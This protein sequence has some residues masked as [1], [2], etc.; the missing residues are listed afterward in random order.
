VAPP[1]GRVL[2]RS[3]GLQPGE[4]GAERSRLAVGGDELDPRCSPALVEDLAGVAPAYVAT[5]GFDPLRD[6]GEEYA[7][8]LRGDGVGVALRRH[9]DLIHGFVNTV[10]VGH[11]GKDALLEAAGALRV[12]VARATR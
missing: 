3:D 9:S 1:L 6:E 12:G 4:L 5:A 2:G 10:G 8:R 11:V 7:A